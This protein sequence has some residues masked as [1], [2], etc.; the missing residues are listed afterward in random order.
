MINNLWENSVLLEIWSKDNNAMP[1]RSYW[2]PLPPQSLMITE[3][4]RSTITSTFG[5]VFVDDFGAGTAEIVISGIT[6]FRPFSARAGDGYGKVLSQS[7][8]E[9]FEY[10]RDEIFR[11]KRYG[12]DAEYGKYYVK[13]YDYT[14][15]INK[16]LQSRKSRHAS[17]WI[18]ALPNSIEAS[19]SKDAPSQTSWTLNLTGIRPTDKPESNDYGSDILNGLNA[20]DEV[21]SSARTAINDILDYLRAPGVY[22]VRIRSSANNILGLLDEATAGM[23]S[24]INTAGEIVNFPA[25]LVE[26]LW[27]G[28]KSFYDEV[29]YFPSKANDEWQSVKK[30]WNDII[31]GV[32]SLFSSAKTLKITEKSY[33]KSSQQP[34]VFEFTST[35]S[36]IKNS[37]TITETIYVYDGFKITVN[38]YESIEDIAKRYLGD[39]AYARL[40]LAYN[41]IQSKDDIFVGS[42]ITIPVLAENYTAASENIFTLD[43]RDLLGKDI[44]LDINGNLQVAGNDFLIIEDLDNIEQALILRLRERIN[45]RSRL[46]AYGLGVSVGNASLGNRYIADNIKETILKDKRVLSISAPVTIESNADILRYQARVLLRNKETVAISGAA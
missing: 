41:K 23:N 21:I 3:N 39:A 1:E 13:F 44:A 9:A 33:G 22:M 5:G 15:S 43:S 20:L 46:Y 34:Q 30:S 38:A 6:S 16:N 19:K 26:S 10:L 18:C 45:S 28:I 37:E 17:G 27:T 14:D 35:S 31:K 32:K 40:I 25:A 42:D 24:V 8:L 7:G 36:N 4:S 11:Y 2:M 12:S 29:R